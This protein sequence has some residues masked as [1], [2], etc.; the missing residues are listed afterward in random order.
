MAKGIDITRRGLVLG[1]AAAALVPG[2]PAWAREVDWQVA[3]AASRIGFAYSLNGKPAEGRFDAVTGGGRFDPAD[4]SGA[5]LEMRI[6][7]G[8]IDLGNPVFSA[9][10][11]SAE[12]FDAR[13]HPEVVYRLTGLE[14]LGGPDYRAH[15]EIELRGRTGR[16]VSDIRLEV[17]EGEARASGRL[18]LDRTDYLLGVGPSSLVVDVGRE[19]TVSFDLVARRT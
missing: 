13:N 10:A 17:V 4:P 8:S 3:P 18:S 2:L 6:A 15:G 7:A 11:T 19:V 1:A 12:W 5:L 9:F 14:P 16:S